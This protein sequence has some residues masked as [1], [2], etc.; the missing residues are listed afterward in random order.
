MSGLCVLHS[1]AFLELGSRYVNELG[2]SS[3]VG[4]VNVGGNDAMSLLWSRSQR[5]V[6][7]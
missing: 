1:I 7:V 3:D 2:L 6:G 5:D 4:F